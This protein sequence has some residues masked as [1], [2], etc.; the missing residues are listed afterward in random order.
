MLLVAFLVPSA[1]S[2][3]THLWDLTAGGA[4]RD[5]GYSVT[6]DDE[7]N[8]YVAG[9][10]SGV[11]DFGGGERTSA[12]GEDIFVVKFDSDGNY[13]WDLTYGDGADDD[14]AYSIDTDSRGNL[15]VCGSFVG[16]VNFGG[17][18]RRS[19]GGL[20]IFVLKLDGD[21]SWIW[22]RTFGN[23]NNQAGVAL[24]VDGENNVIVTG[25]F[26]LPLDFG[27]GLRPPVGR[28]DIFVVKLDDDGD[29]LWDRTFGSVGRD[30]GRRVAIDDHN[31][32]YIVGN[33]ENT[34]DFGG[35]A[36]T[37][38]D[39]EYYDSYL[40][41]L[42]SDGD[43]MADRTWGGAGEDANWGTVVNSGGVYVTGYFAETVDFGGGAR[44]AV[45]SSDACVIKFDSHLE[46]L[47]DRTYG[48]DGEEFGYD[49]AFLTS[50][51]LF[52]TGSFENVVDFGGGL[53]TSAGDKDIFILELD[54]DGGYMWDNAVGGTALDRSQGI[55]VDLSQGMHLTGYFGDVIDFG[56]GDRTSNGSTD[57][58]LVKY[59]A[60]IPATI[61]IDPNTL[62]M[63]SNGR[64]IICRIELGDEFDVRD[65][66]LSTILL[67]G[68]VP[69]AVKH[70]NLKPKHRWN[71]HGEWSSSK[72][73]WHIE[74]Y[75]CDDIPDLMVKFDR[76]E[77]VSI[78]EPG[79]EVPIVITGYV[80]DVKFKGTDFIRVID[81]SSDSE[82]EKED[83]PS[84]KEDSFLAYPNPFNPAVRIEYAVQKSSRVLVQIFDAKGALVT[85]I[86]D[87]QRVPGDYSADWNGKNRSGAAVVSGVYFCRLS[88]GREVSIKKLMLLR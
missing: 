85:T 40:L 75:D 18:P 35:G 5:E 37:E 33:F 81:E 87:A 70:G 15:L 24:A 28:R 55:F 2:G 17:G 82:E 42:D 52:V 62:N 12:G 7:G 43:Y 57:I 78:L 31:D 51:L 22:D 48:S 71:N 79:C 63:E 49:I 46:Y 6:L 64:Y 86:E 38:G 29:Y 83:E 74:D 16:R 67:N 26:R 23:R 60:P 1:S 73:R 77:V 47:W 32:I 19:V 21:G 56:G 9:S 66:D 45:G 80:G 14:I 11:V 44:T 10:F 4:N 30:A 41:K 88:I 59:D 34:I 69:I 58:F 20:D 27:G 39:N 13:L 76:Q 61:D 54:S 25:R 65:I 50:E 3:Q 72:Y 8:V 68:V 84:V 36:R 53:R